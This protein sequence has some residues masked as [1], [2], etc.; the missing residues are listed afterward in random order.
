VWTISTDDTTYYKFQDE[1]DLTAGAAS[2]GSFVVPSNAPSA[3]AAAGCTLS[4]FW[5][6][7]SSGGCEVYQ[8]C[9]NVKITGAAGGMESSAPSISTNPTNPIIS[10]CVRVDPTTHLTPHFAGLSDEGTEGGESAGPVPGQEVEGDCVTYTVQSGDTLSAIAD[11]YDV[12]GGYQ[13]IFEANKDV[14]VS[15][16]SIEIGMKLV[17][18]GSD[19]DSSKKKNAGG[20]G[21]GG[22]AGIVLSLFGVSMF[23]GFM[24]KQKIKSGKHAL[25]GGKDNEMI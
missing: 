4:W 8:N 13:A 22:I 10:N 21:G 6:P 2:G 3:C 20:L 16:D 7:V 11:T 5:T 19:C 14:L 25:K 18:P 12:D 15:A 23:A 9:F 24:L 1:V 17:I